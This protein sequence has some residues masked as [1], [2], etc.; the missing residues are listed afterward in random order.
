M[1]GTAADRAAAAWAE[2]NGR[3]AR[4][5]PKGSFAELGDAMALVTNCQVWSLNA[6]ASIATRPDLAALDAMA[7]EVAR[8]AVPWSIVVRAEAAESSADLAARHGRTTRVDVD[9]LACA[10]NDAVLTADEKELTAIRR[11]GSGSADLY[12]AA[13]A[14]GFEVPVSV[15]GSLM[16]GGVLDLPSF[17]GYLSGPA[18]RPVATGF[19]MRSP[20]AVGVYNIAVAPRMRRHGLGRAMTARVMTDAFAAGADVAYLHTSDEGRALYESMGFRPVDTYCYFTAP[21]S[22]GAA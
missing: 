11:I 7:T 15:F 20:G 14:E 12:T 22:A 1:T 13:L 16:G 21:E 6:A 4:V 3:L 8:F 17:A 9:M 19:A 5:T 2:T 18:E 10:A